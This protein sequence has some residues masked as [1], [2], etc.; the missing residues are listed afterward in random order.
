MTWTILLMLMYADHFQVIKHSIKTRLRLHLDTFPAP[1]VTNHEKPVSTC[2]N[3]NDVGMTC[4]Q[5]AKDMF[6]NMLLLSPHSY[7]KDIRVLKAP[8]QS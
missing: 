3:D 4:L 1:E 8:S 5:Q 7:L 6:N 2:S